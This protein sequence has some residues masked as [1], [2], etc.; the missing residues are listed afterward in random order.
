[1]PLKDDYK[2]IEVRFLEI[3]KE[4]LIKK[5]LELGA[6]DLGED[7]L[8]E[9]IMYDKDLTWRDHTNTRIRLRTQ[10]GI[11]KLSFKHRESK[12]IGDT[13]EIEFVVDDAA[14]AELFVNKLGYPSIRHQEKM[15]HTFELNGVTLDIDTWPKVPTYVEIEGTSEN[16][17]KK[18]ADLLG[19]NWNDVVLDNPRAVIE[20]RYNIP[21]GKM[22]YFTFDRFE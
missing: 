15:R 5:L 17:L 10:K 4:S 20:N 13:E 22:T 2:E 12:A 7:L 1:M 8:K 11:T 19:L 21:V 9:I 16:D 14:K 3:D 18:M 6:R